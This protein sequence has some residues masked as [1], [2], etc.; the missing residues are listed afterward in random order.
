MSN[1]KDI[2]SIK[3]PAGKRTC[4]IDVKETREGAKYLKISEN[5]RLEDGSYKRHQVMI[6][7]R[8]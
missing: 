6:L 8:I 5:K 1:E 3:V 7:K 4:F 2:Q